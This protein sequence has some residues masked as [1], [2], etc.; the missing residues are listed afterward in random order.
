[1]INDQLAL[2]NNYLRFVIDNKDEFSQL[3]NDAKKE[4]PYNINLLDEVRVDE[5]AHSRIFIKLLQYEYRGDFTLLRSFLNYLGTPFSNLII[6]RPEMTAEVNRIDIR[7]R[8]LVGKFSV[9]IENKIN[10]AKDQNEQ[11]KRYIQIEK[12]IIDNEDQ[13]YILYLTSEGGSPSENSFPEYLRKS[14][15]DRYKEINYKYYILPWI[16]EIIEK[17]IPTIFE[18]NNN[19]A[20]LLETAAFQYKNYLEGLF[21][22]REGE[23]EMADKMVKFLQD[24]L[25]LKNLKN[26]SEKLDKINEFKR[27]NE[28][29]ISYLHETEKDILYSELNIFS[30]RIC[31]K[32]NEINGI[33]N[34]L[35]VGN[36]GE[37]ASC[38]SFIPKEWNERYTINLSFNHD[39][40][41]L[42]YGICDSQGTFKTAK[43]PL[44]SKLKKILGKNDEPNDL[45]LYS[46][47]IFDDLDDLEFF[48]KLITEIENN[49]LMDFV[50]TKVIEL[51]GNEEIAVLLK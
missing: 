44:I 22:K 11:I 12:N 25:D 14:F 18:L 45:W 50:E 20:R 43:N 30:K 10:Y 37:E 17:V 5:N 32:N 48:E 51:I 21:N 13:I 19:K 35:I 6:Q 16:N 2:E 47:W 9:I 27:Y 42:F 29:L 1:M 49:N 3:Y 8:D 39:L 15:F 7:I 34:I 28:N 40:S 24:K 38:I 46:K 23:K 33:K 36:F 26:S 41:D 31:N 4:I